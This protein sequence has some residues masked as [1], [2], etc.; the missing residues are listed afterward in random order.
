ML[1]NQTL[2]TTRTLFSLSVTETGKR[3]RVPRAGP[4]K[5]GYGGKIGGA[6]KEAAKASCGEM[7]V[8]KRVLEE[9]VS[10]L[11]AEVFKCLK[12]KP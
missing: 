9:S 4:P 12:G 3:S 8:Q 5:K 7:V 11:P 10:S 6:P 2:K 1:K